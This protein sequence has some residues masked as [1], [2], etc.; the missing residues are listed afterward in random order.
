MAKYQH[1][2]DAVAGMPPFSGVI[3]SDGKWVA[4]MATSEDW[5]EYLD[6]ARDGKNHPDPYK[7][8]SDGGVVIK[9]EEGQVAYGAMLDSLPPEPTTGSE[10]PKPAQA[11]PP[12]S[13][14]TKK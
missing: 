3:R 9:L 8:P 14:P 2:S 7:S 11:P 1:A 13:A 5:E 4:N 12:P 10:P 6:W